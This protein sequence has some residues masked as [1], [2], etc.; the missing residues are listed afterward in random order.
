MNNEE[1]NRLI[2]WWFS[3]TQT[4][5]YRRWFGKNVDVDEFVAK[6]WED[7]LHILE[8]MLNNSFRNLT[9]KLISLL[10]IQLLGG[11]L[12]LDQVSRHIYRKNPQKV[13]QNTKLSVYFCKQLFKNLK[14][15]KTLKKDKISDEHLIF[16]LMPF[17]HDDILE[18]FPFIE[19]QID[20]FSESGV[21][22]STISRFYRDS[23]KKYLISKNDDV[24]KNPKLVSAHD[25]S[26]FRQ[27]TVNSYLKLIINID[28]I[29]NEKLIFL[30]VGTMILG[31][32]GGLLFKTTLCLAAY[33]F[34]QILRGYFNIFRDICEHLPDKYNHIGWD[35]DVDIS[36]NDY[37]IVRQVYT[38]ITKDLD[39]ECT[40]IV[41]SLSG[42]VDSML[43]CYLLKVF[44]QKMLKMSSTSSPQ[45][46]HLRAVHINYRNRPESDLEQLFVENYCFKMKIP[47]YVRVIDNVTRSTTDRKWYESVTR[48]IRFDLYKKIL[49]KNGNDGDTEGY[50]VLGHIRDDAVENIFTNFAKGQHIFNLKKL[51]PVSEMYG[52]SIWRPLIN[53]NKTDILE[54]AH[55]LSIPWLKNTTPEWSNRGKLRNQ[56]IPAVEEQFGKKC[57]E[58]VEYVA[59]TLTEYSEIITKLLID[60][61]IDVHTDVCWDDFGTKTVIP[62]SYVHLGVHFWQNVLLRIFYSRK[63]GLPSRKS[64]RHFVNTIRGNKSTIINL[65]KEVYCYYECQPDNINNVGTVYILDS[66]KVSYS[67]KVDRKKLGNGHWKKIKILL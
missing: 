55:Q 61:M 12:M 42:G 6:N 59:D 60:P 22:S 28:N 25:F 21:N 19:E 38:R 27:K 9:K 31:Y 50:I 58:N 15:L 36:S 4:E 40:N 52:V 53:S 62:E 37:N 5:K 3:G 47:L 66:E 10:N 26:D 34:V 11:I 20:L 45:H 13:V 44:Q 63:V 8:L 39:E 67:I 56:F 29:I 64:I 46:F 54:L 7:Q 23:K 51:E 41:V 35:V 30:T 57:F 17:K 16:A 48:A 33:Y 43:L 14:N 49:A 18:Y 1:S 65:R 24:V 32:L 2:D